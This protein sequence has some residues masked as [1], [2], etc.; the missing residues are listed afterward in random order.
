LQRDLVITH[1]SIKYLKPVSQDFTVRA[2]VD[3]KMWKSFTSA[4]AQSKPQRLR[5]QAHIH[6]AGKA[7]SLCQFDGE[8]ALL[9]SKSEGALN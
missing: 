9:P 1:G 7:D 3:L 2:F 5:I 8:F 4:L 6:V